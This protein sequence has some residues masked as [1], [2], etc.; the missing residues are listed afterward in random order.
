MTNW[1]RT[2]S[3]IVIIRSDQ[4]Y[5]LLCGLSGLSSN[6]VCWLPG[7]SCKGMSSVAT[8][9]L[10]SSGQT[11]L[12]GLSM[13]WPLCSKV[14]PLMTPSLPWTWRIILPFFHFASF[15]SSPTTSTISPMSGTG[16]VF[17]LTQWLS[18]KLCM[19][20]C[21]HLFHACCL[22]SFSRL[23]SLLTLSLSSSVSSISCAFCLHISSFGSKLV[24]SL[25]HFR[26]MSKGGCSFASLCRLS[27]SQAVRNSG[28]R[29]QR[30]SFLQLAIQA[31]WS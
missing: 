11:K 29:V 13:W 16:P 30:K 17:L 27:P 2:S 23:W 10:I 12:S 19:Y 20:L 28:F 1:T 15:F 3:V 22:A 14:T 18:N 25:P 5:F 31:S 8:G 4:S 7:I 6:P 9:P 26:G 21:F 24:P